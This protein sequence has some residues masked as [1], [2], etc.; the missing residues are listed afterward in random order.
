MKK[1]NLTIK[2]LVYLAVFSIFI[3]LFIWIVQVVFLGVIYERYQ[4]K[5]IESV[6]KNIQNNA[7]NITQSLED[8]AYKYD[9]CI[10]YHQGDTTIGYN[11]K[12][13]GCLLGLDSHKIALYKNHLLTTNDEYIKIYAPNTG[14]KSIIY[15]IRLN[16]TEYVFLNTTLEDINT[17]TILLKRQLIY[18]ILL[19]LIVSIIMAIFISKR[20]N[21]PILKLIEGA[22]ELGKGNYNVVF[23]KSNIQE[24]DELASVLTVAASEMNKTDELRRDLLAN[25]SHD[26]KTPLTMIKAYAEKVRD[27][28][29]KDDEKRTNDL[30]VIIDESDRLNI[31]VNDLLELSKLEAKKVDLNITKYDLVADIQEILKRYDIIRER[32]NY[33]FIVDLPKVAYVK[34]DKNKIDQV[35]YNLINN[36]IEH[37]GDDLTVKIKVKKQRDYYVV[38]IT[39]TG[40]GIES[41][42]IPLIWNKYYKT[43]KNH[44]RNKVGSGIG[45]SIVKEVLEIHKFPYGID[46]KV[47]KYTTVYFKIK[48]SN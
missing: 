39:D 27:L 17:A 15:F 4:I 43:E 23:E 3:L 12:N 29:Y 33:N 21:K 8:Y 42:D 28:S 46:S 5:N 2:T 19:L 47:G 9:M 16:D 1:N 45:L 10:E 22:K 25:V 30:N 13:Q 40:E 48:K 11:L 31:L 7:T 34:A 44:K 37:T 6:S 32:E 41:K 20:I 35:I 14:K 38:E 24:L 36:A 18:I 26:L